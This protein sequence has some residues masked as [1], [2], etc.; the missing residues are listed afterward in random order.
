MKWDEALNR[1]FTP[2]NEEDQLPDDT[3]YSAADTLQEEKRKTM[4]RSN[5]SETDTSTSQNQIGKGT[6]IIGDITSTGSF[7]IDGDFEGN[8]QSSGKVVIGESGSVKGTVTTTEM[9][10][11]GKIKGKI[12]VNELLSLRS[13]ARV[14]GEVSTSKLAVEPGATFNATCDMNSNA[15]RAIKTLD[16]REK[17]EKPA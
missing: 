13:T 3:N 15:T 11:A 14:E 9:E 17:T 7:K 2:A 12:T 8:I 4:S 6:K 16:G 5:S 1:Y 10:I